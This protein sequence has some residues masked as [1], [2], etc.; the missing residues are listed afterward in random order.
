MGARASVSLRSMPGPGRSHN[1]RTIRS[2]AQQEYQSIYQ[3]TSTARY[4][5]EQAQ[6]WHNPTALGGATCTSPT[7][8]HP[9]G[10]ECNRASTACTRPPGRSYQAVQAT[11]S[12]RCLP[13]AAGVP[14]SSRLQQARVP[15][16]TSTGPDTCPAAT[17]GCPVIVLKT[18]TKNT[19]TASNGCLVF[20]GG[21]LPFG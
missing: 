14:C 2:I 12:N 13:C 8:Q 1:H 21:Q 17:Q 20:A 4:P 3:D 15:E 9:V 6:P 10:P 18:F 7:Y 16:G 19:R 5:R 11:G